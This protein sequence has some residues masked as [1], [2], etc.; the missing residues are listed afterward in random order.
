MK[1][2]VQKEVVQEKV[3]FENSSLIEFITYDFG[4]QTMQVKYKRGKHK[5]TLR[6]YEG[7]PKDAYEEIL[8][9]PSS[10]GKALLKVIGRYRK[11]ET[12]FWH[13][14]RNLLSFRKEGGY[15]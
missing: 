9:A 2:I 7:I 10:H 6:T 13:T 5:G 1:D 4:T 12:G 3:S 14:L 11:K 8:N 15:Y